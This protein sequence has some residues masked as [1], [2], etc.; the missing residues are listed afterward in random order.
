MSAALKRVERALIE[1][2]NFI[3]LREDLATLLRLAKQAAAYRLVVGRLPEPHRS[4]VGIL[5]EPRNSAR[6][7]R[8][9]AVLGKLKSGR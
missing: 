2:G 9:A 4:S 6:W 1:G 7:R 3:V 5:V 8:A